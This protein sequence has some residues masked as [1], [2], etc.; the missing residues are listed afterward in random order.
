MNKLEGIVKQLKQ[1][2]ANEQETI[3]EMLY[4]AGIVASFGKRIFIKNILE[5]DVDGLKAENN[6]T[7]NAMYDVVGLD[8]FAIVEHVTV[9]RFTMTWDEIERDGGVAAVV[10]EIKEEYKIA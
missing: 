2:D 3:K 9:D 4:D 7:I 8:G 1:L 10:E 5:V 6:Y